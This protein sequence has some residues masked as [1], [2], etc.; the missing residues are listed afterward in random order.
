MKI[1]IQEQLK[2][3]VIKENYSEERIREL[4]TSGADLNY[5]YK[6]EETIL[7][8]VI[9]CRLITLYNI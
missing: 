2:A 3:E 1:Y 8:D 6:T 5:T 9:V 7:R 4:V